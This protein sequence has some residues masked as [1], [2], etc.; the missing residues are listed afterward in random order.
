MMST[1]DFGRKAP[2]FSRLLALCLVGVVLVCGGC[3]K[4]RSAPVVL[5]ESITAVPDAGQPIAVAPTATPEPGPKEE[6]PSQACGSG[7]VG[8]VCHDVAQRGQLVT[9]K[10]GGAK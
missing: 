10:K 7:S 1:R 8:K 9:E 2:I 3:K 6:E 5:P 4:K